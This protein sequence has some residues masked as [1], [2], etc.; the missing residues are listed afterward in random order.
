MVCLRLDNLI[1]LLAPVKAANGEDSEACSN[2]PEPVEV[3]D[4]LSW[5]FDVHTPHAADDVHGKDDCAYDLEE[6]QTGTRACRGKIAVCGEWRDA[7]KSKRKEWA[8]REVER[9]GE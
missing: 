4:F 7:L 9:A 2:T 1:D 6:C 5:D 3:V 8:G